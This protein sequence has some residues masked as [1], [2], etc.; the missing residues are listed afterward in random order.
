M[1]VKASIKKRSADYLLK[2]MEE[3][4]FFEYYRE[5]GPKIHA[6]WGNGP[7]IFSRET[8]QPLIGG[9]MDQKYWL[10]LSQFGALSIMGYSIYITCTHH[11][12]ND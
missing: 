10:I 3:N 6:Y 2:K 1:K 5:N 4:K 7:K 12:Q 9:E 8:N 11:T